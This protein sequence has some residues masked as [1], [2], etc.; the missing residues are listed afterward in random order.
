MT[1]T[2]YKETTW[3]NK[4]IEC[5]KKNSRKIF[6]VFA[7]IIVVGWVISLNV[8]CFNSWLRESGLLLSLILL[9]VLDISASI[10]SQDTTP[11]T[12]LEEKQD[13]SMPKM[14]NI[15]KQCNSTKDKADLLEYAG[16]TTLPL[17]RGIRDQGLAIRILAQHP[18]LL[19]G[20]QKKRSIVILDTLYNDIFNNYSSNYQIR[21]YR[22]PYTLRGRKI[23]NQVLELGW[24]TPNI[25]QAT[26]F[27]HENPSIIVDLSVKKNEYLV[28]FFDKTFNDLWND[29]L[30]EDGKAVLENNKS[31]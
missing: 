9:I 4:I 19:T 25:K 23:E 10:H 30:T 15:V 13:L 17:I 7:A 3:L 21:C 1:K 16:Q 18:D 11:P 27:G 12:Y 5:Y 2:G 29:S 26:A 24:L 14:I 28:S 6:I 31:V 22:Q 8:T 20:L